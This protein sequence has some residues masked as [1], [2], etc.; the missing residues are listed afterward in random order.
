MPPVGCNSQREG[1]GVSQVCTQTAHIDSAAAAGAEAEAACRTDSTAEGTAAAWVQQGAVAVLR[2]CCFCCCWCPRALPILA[3]SRTVPAYHHLW[4]C[5][6]T[7]CCC[8]CPWPSYM[9]QLQRLLLLPPSC[10]M[11]LPTQLALVNTQ[12]TAA[13]AAPAPFDA[14]VAACADLLLLLLPVPALRL[15]CV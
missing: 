6:N 8:C 11:A 7:P 13:A 10:C 5:P 3:E 14:A 12:A 4:P 1:R 15:P 2:S 9:H